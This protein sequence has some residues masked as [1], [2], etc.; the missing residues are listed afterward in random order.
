M[1]SAGVSS[2]DQVVDSY[3]RSEDFRRLQSTNRESA[4]RIDSNFQRA[5]S[6]R[7]SAGTDLRTAQ[8]QREL[9]QKAETL[10]RNL[11]YNNVVEWNRYLRDR[12]LEGETDKN[13]L[14]AAVPACQ[15]GR[16][17]CRERV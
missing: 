3:M 15:I 2:V 17:S 16:A 10:S 4:Q 8:E 6:Y 13:L 1:E 11:N 12:G 14:A 5:T 7:E 9:S